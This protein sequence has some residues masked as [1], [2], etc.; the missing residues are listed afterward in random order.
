MNMAIDFKMR[1][2]GSY[3]DFTDKHTP[4]VHLHKYRIK[5]T[6]YGYVC[7]TTLSSISTAIRNMV[8]CLIHSRDERN[9]IFLITNNWL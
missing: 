7:N 2:E 9:L 8:P 3:G 5:T 1:M 6:T 4:Y